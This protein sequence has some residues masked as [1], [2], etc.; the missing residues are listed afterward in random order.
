[1][2]ELINHSP[3]GLSLY[4]PEAGD[5]IFYNVGERGAED[6]AQRFL[7]DRDKA[8][9]VMIVL[10][11]HSSSWSEGYQCWQVMI[12]NQLLDSINVGFKLSDKHVV[13]VKVIR[14]GQV[15]IDWRR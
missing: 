14:N 7:V 3:E 5:I 8:S 2:S 6:L 15:H 13:Y 1:M 9:D 10:I 4:A 11:E 12:S